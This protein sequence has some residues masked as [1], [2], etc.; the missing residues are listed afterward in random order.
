MDFKAVS[1][2]TPNRTT[3]VYRPAQTGFLMAWLK[4]PKKHIPIVLSILIEE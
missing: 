2:C 1:D 4:T 3:A